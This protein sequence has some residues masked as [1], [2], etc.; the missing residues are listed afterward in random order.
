MATL[1][2]GE[3]IPMSW[4]EY[5]ALGEN[6]RGE[7]IDGLLVMSPSATGPHQD[8]ARHLANLLEAALP[9][10]VKV[11]MAWSWKP[12]GDEFIPD[13]IVFDRTEEIVRYTG[14]PHLAVEVLSTDFGADLVRK[15]HKYGRVGLPQYWVINPE[16][17]ELFV[18]KQSGTGA[19]MEVG[20]FGS[21]DVADL[22]VAGERV[23]FRPSDLIRS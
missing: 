19:L 10:E 7:Y 2:A 13:V 22:E 12:A 17:P 9:P 23:A 8:I 16:G 1:Q 3:R 21:D 18:Y 15:H 20:R 11:R 14:M 6:V 5:E 4:E